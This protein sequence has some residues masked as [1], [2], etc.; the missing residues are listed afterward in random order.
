MPGDF[1]ARSLASR[2]C[3]TISSTWPSTMRPTRFKYARRWRSMS[4]SSSGLRRSQSTMPTRTTAATPASGS[5]SCQSFRSSFNANLFRCGYILRGDA[6]ISQRADSADADFHDVA[7]GQRAH[8]RGRAGRDHV[9]GFQR[10]H[11]CD[12]AHY[13]ITAKDHFRRVSRLFPDSIHVG[14]HG[15]TGGIELGF[16]DRAEGAESIEALSARELHVEFLQ[17]AGGHVVEAGVAQDVGAD[18]FAVFRVIAPARDDD[19]QLAFLVHAP[20]D[21]RVDDGFFRSDDRRGRFKKNK[22]PSGRFIA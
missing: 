18:V 3:S 11:L 9:A 13:N 8:A 7:C 5:Q 14:F 17:V 4:L 6:R 1:A 10:H 21:A 12:E 2:V 20:R 22:W 15:D 19:G 16:D